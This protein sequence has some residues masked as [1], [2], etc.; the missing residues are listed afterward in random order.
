MKNGD[1]VLSDLQV[2]IGA[3]TREEEFLATPLGK[4]AKPLVFNGPFHSYYTEPHI[5]EGRS[6]LLKLY[7][8]VS[9]LRTIHL[10]ST[11]NQV[12]SWEEVNASTLSRAKAVND[13]WLRDT[14]GIGSFTEFHWGKIESTYDEKSW[15]ADVIIS[16]H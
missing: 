8:E 11:E 1:L 15:A 5:V 2:T 3:Q 7:F 12:Q 14:L 4:E 6:F 9:K 10:S 13:R 16:Y